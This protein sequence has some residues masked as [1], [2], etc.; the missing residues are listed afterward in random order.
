MNTFVYVIGLFGA[1]L[2]GII[3]LLAGGS[4]NA[5]DYTSLNSL[6]DMEGPLGSLL[7]ELDIFNIWMLI[8]SA[9]GLHIVGRF[10]KKA[11]WSVMIILFIL[12]AGIGMI[13]EALS[14]FTAD[15]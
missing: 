6:V 11:A 9:I 15:L 8:L 12:T 1:I 13:G 2:N 4:E 14:M 10:S 3:F 7:A 5:A